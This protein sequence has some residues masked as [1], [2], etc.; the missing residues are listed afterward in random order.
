M[1]SSAIVAAALV[2]LVGLGGRA[3]GQ[4]EASTNEVN[5]LQTA[6]R[7]G[8]VQKGP[9]GVP[10]FLARLAGPPPTFAPDLVVDL[11]A[12]GHL[13]VVTPER[14]TSL[15]RVD[16]AKATWVSFRKHK[17]LHVALFDDAQQK[18]FEGAIARPGA[19]VYLNVRPGWDGDRCQRALETLAL[20][21]RAA[22]GDD[23]A[24]D[25]AQ[26]L[27]QAQDDRVA[28]ALLAE[29]CGR[30][31]PGSPGAPPAPKA[32]PDLVALTDAELQDLLGS[33][34]K[35]PFDDKKLPVLDSHATGRHAY[36]VEQASR[37][38]KT[39]SFDKG[40]VSALEILAPRI[41]DRENFFRLYDLIQFDDG[42]KALKAV[43][44]KL[45]ARPQGDAPVACTKE[46][47]DEIQRRLAKEPFDQGKLPVL[48]SASASRSFTCEQAA[49]L[50]KSFAFG[51]GQVGAVKV[52]LPHL[53][54]RENFFKV[55]DAI[56]FETDKAK[57][58]QLEKESR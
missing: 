39:F 45:G 2:A 14:E 12:A 9:S 24:L 58:R 33:L 16:A 51:E 10:F 46:D 38:A 52:L 35:V 57:A 36:T 30:P 40:K 7:D 50:V 31:A 5:W 37:I 4:D 18:I 43:E 27:P 6:A 55:V 25:K 13:V 44:K 26:K 42:K 41:L 28:A 34:A 47:L 29:V 17:V 53:R 23:A 8:S 32:E 15:V 22:S 20:L 1:R 11:P 48:T 3:K 54:D 49:R 21:A 19:R 56:T